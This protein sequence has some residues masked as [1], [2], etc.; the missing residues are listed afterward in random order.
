MQKINCQRII[1]NFWDGV[2]D[3]LDSVRRVLRGGAFNYYEGHVRCA[4]RFRYSPHYRGYYFG[5]RVVASPFTS[6]L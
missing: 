5:F 6:G 2:L 1:Q 4:F 3:A